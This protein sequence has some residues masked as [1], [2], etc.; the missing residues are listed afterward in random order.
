MSCSK[1]NAENEVIHK[2][3]K[4]IDEIDFKIVSLSSFQLPLICENH[5]RYAAYSAS[6]RPDVNLGLF[7]N[8]L[9]N[10]I[11]VLHERLK[12][13]GLDEQEVTFV[14]TSIHKICNPLLIQ[15][16][17]LEMVKA[18]QTYHACFETIIQQM[19]TLAKLSGF[20]LYILIVQI[21]APESFLLATKN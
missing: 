1:Q 20:S 16:P 9:Q 2:V 5:I 3:S 8:T 17:L 4:A 15:M 11:N 10:F 19:H 6:I 13:N 14:T 18:K 7:L 21:G 12:T